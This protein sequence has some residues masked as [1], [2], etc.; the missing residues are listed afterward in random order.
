MT[1]NLKK[2]LEKYPELEESYNTVPIVADGLH[3]SEDLIEA[4]VTTIIAFS[5]SNKT[6]EEKLTEKYLNEP[7]RLIVDMNNFN[8]IKELIEK[9]EK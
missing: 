8:Q 4:M 6:I 7:A 3:S 1:N 5:I 2:L 9:S